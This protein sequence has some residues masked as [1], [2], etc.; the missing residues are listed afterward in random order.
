MVAARSYAMAF[1][2]LADLTLDRINPRTADRPL[3]TGAITVS[4]ARWFCV[5]TAV[6]FVAACACLNELCLVLSVPALAFATAYSYVKR[7]SSVCHF[8]LGATLGLAP[9]AGW[10]SVNPQSITVAPLLLCFAVTF[11]VGAFDI[12]YAFL[13]I[14]FDRREGIHSLPADAGEGTAMAVAAFAHVVTILLL[15][16]A[17]FS[18]GLSWPWYAVCGVIGLLFVL[19]HLAMRSGDS[20]HVN[21][22]FFVLNGFVSPVMLVGVILGIWW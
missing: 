3:V 14:D 19:E 13:D 8:W 7:V 2:R 22:A 18:A 17:G 5:A 6:V 21:I 20:R 15:G 11:W 10:I 4:S 16:L 9:L 1:N 12:F